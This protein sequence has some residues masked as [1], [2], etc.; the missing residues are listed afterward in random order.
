MSGWKT[1]A[2]AALSILYGLVGW[3]LGLHGADQAMNYVITGMGLI[4][5]GH[6]IEKVGNVI[7]KAK[8]DELLDLVKR[9]MP[10]PKPEPDGVRTDVKDRGR[11]G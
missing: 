7:E 5:V 1:K 8:T 2:A 9:N 3:A 6:K 11:G 10:K 4:G